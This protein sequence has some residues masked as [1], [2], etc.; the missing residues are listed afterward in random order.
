MKKILFIL[1]SSLVLVSCEGY[2]D[3]LPKTELPAETF[4]TSYDAALRNAAILSPYI[5]AR[6]I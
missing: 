6:R 3:Q 2:F 1:L 5:S 4:Y